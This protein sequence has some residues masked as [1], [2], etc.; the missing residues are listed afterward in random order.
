MAGSPI[1]VKNYQ[2]LRDKI[3]KPV[4]GLDGIFSLK[5]LVE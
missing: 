1:D 4:A 3:P 5:R 2:A